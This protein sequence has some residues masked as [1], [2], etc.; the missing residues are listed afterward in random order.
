MT[1]RSQLQ[2]ASLLALA[3]AGLD[4]ATKRWAESSLEEPIRIVAGLRL[5]LGHNSGIAFGALTDLPT[6]WL[7]AA[8]T[9]L[10]VALTVAVVRG[11]LPI[12]WPAAGLLLGGAVGNL[13]DRVGDGVVTDFIDPA[14]WPAFNL[15]DVAITFAVVLMLWRSI[16][17]ERIGDSPSTG[18][19]RSQPHG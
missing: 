13:I 17:D 7:I 1:R 4:L 9:A 14:R 19:Y 2:W 5:E 15:A 18:F 3:V 6:G 12:P 8:V 16:R 11:A 10:V